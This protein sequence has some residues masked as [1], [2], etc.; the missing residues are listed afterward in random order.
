MGGN[1]SVRRHCISQAAS[2]QRTS[3][4]KSPWLQHFLDIER[5]VIVF[6]CFCHL[7]DVGTE[8]KVIALVEEKKK[9]YLIKRSKNIIVS[10][11]TR[12]PFHRRCPK[13]SEHR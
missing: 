4:Q 7:S 6:E 12:A 3:N 13:R 11:K 2:F 1:P 10:P 8:E 5:Q 9:R